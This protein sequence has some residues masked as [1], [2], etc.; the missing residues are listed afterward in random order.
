MPASR[1]DSASVRSLAPCWKYVERR[2]LDPVGAVAEVDRVQVRLQDPLLRP[3]LR[4]L[5]LPRVGGLAHLAGDRLLVA[6]E[7]VLD[8]LLRD[9]RA[10]LDDALAANVRDER[11]ADATEVDPVVLPEAPVL[12]CDDRVPHRVG[13]LVVADQRPRLRAAQDG[14]DPRRLLVR[15]V[16]VAVHLLVQLALRI[17]LAGVDLGGDGADQPEAERH[18]PDDQEDGEERKEAKLADPAA[19]P[20]TLFPAEHPQGVHGSPRKAVRRLRSRRG[21]RRRSVPASSGRSP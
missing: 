5:E 8:E 9:R 6:V 12:D 1:A 14:E 2:L 13:D 20:R 18:R 15:V 16:D 17:E 4:A 19:R 11:A 21:R 10:A 7:R 3:G